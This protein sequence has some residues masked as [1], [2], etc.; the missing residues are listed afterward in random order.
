MNL[1]FYTKIRKELPIP[2]ENNAL[3]L[4]NIEKFILSKKAEN[5]NIKANEL[6]F[7]MSFFGRNWDYFALID[8]G[9]FFISDKEITF[10]FYT[11][12]RFLV[13]FLLCI[14]FIFQTKNISISVIFV[15]MIL[16][17]WVISIVR[18]KKMLKEILN[19][20][21]NNSGIDT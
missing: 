21:E 17:N 6:T 7:K 14:F 18:Y 4:K 20:F 2:I 11:Y 15:L 16:I 3:L 9:V 5:I 10:V 13:M 12:K 1:P 8:K 19:E